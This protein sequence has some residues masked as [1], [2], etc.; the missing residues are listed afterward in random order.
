MPLKDPIKR[1]EY[2]SAYMKKIW[3]PKNKE[4]HLG[5][6]RNLKSKLF[7]HIEDF[8]R[9]SICADCGISGK[10]YPKIL[11]FHHVRGDKKFNVSEYSRQTSSLI[12]IKEEISKCDVVCANCHRIR[13]IYKKGK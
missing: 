10:D 4:K 11:D 6:I 12:K 1:K 2:H 9:V 8:K 5:Y 3:Y 13:T 7:K